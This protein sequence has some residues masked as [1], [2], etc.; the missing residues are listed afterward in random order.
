MKEQISQLS[1]QNRELDIL[2]RR[3][4]KLVCDK[5]LPG[6]TS[7][8][9]L[10]LM[11]VTSPKREE[12]TLPGEIVEQVADKFA[13]SSWHALALLRVGRLRSGEEELRHIG[14]DSIVQCL[15]RL[16]PDRIAKLNDVPQ[17]VAEPNR[18]WLV[19]Y[20]VETHE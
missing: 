4:R 13:R 14:E 10:R 18:E 17:F 19:S 9:L 8:G 15:Q 1:R 6:M 7:S 20:F 12:R 16:C 11:R 3:R 5:F 2:V